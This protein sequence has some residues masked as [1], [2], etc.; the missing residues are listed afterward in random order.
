[1]KRPLI[2]VVA[3]LA[4]AGL[5]AGLVAAAQTSDPIEERA[6][7]PDVDL[8]APPSPPDT[9]LSGRCRGVD[10][11]PQDDLASVVEQRP[12]G[13][14]FCIG[15]GVHRLSRPVVPREG[16]RLIG[17]PGAILSGARPVREWT[18]GNPGQWVAEDQTQ[19]VP[20]SGD[21]FPSLERPE[22]AFN[23]DVFVDDEA[24]DRVLSRDRLTTGRF[25][26]DYAADRIYIAEDPRGRKIEAAVLPLLIRG[27]ED[28]VVITGL[29]LEKAAGLGIDARGARGWTISHNEVRLNHQIGVCSGSHSKVTDNFVHDQGQMGLC[30]SGESLLVARNEIAYNNRAGY[31]TETG[32][33][34]DAAGGKWV[35]AT[36]LVIR[37]NNVHDNGCHGLWTDLNS[38]GV[39]Y[40]D[41]WV[42]DNAGTG[43]VHEI[44]YDAVVRDNV[45]SR[46]EEAGIYVASSPN[47]LVRSNTVL[48]NGLGIIVHQ[49]ADR[50]TGTRGPHE[51][52]GVRVVNNTIVM[53]SGYTGLTQHGGN[54]EVLISHDNSFENNVYWTP[55]DGR[56][57]RLGSERLT[58]GEWSKTGQD[59]G[60][61]FD[62]G[63]VS[64]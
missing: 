27:I 64:G 56:F 49:Q 47:V 21:G 11:S 23:E 10:V 37:N 62:D 12:P 48:R 17:E 50:G 25:Y 16:Q 30:G 28:D 44:S 39:V 4:A 6:A 29:V 24:L 55:H 38:S 63:S 41:N 58:S 9:T 8:P 2:I 7:A 59:E 40:R 22:A 14:T 18:E 20:R 54:E 34:W 33:C 15:T 45:L 42:E 5:V 51:T 60:A 53:T 1:M 46:N 3:V 36:G 31:S 35:F 61:L 32:G 57:W 43:I 26:F 52:R 19:E 13:T